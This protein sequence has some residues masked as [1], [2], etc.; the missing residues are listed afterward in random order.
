MIELSDESGNPVEGI[1]FL[2]LDNGPHPGLPIQDHE[3]PG[4]D[5][6]VLEPGIGIPRVHDAEQEILLG[7]PID[8][9]FR[10]GEEPPS[11]SICSI[12]LPILA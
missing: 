10:S 3:G 4:M 12:S 9:R 2:P 5:E 8:L 1:R 11:S 6:P 7:D